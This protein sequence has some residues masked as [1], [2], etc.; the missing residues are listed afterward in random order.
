VATGQELRILQG[1]TSR[2]QGVAFS[3]DGARL[4]SAGAGVVKLWDA[5]TGQELR[6]LQGGGVGVAFSPDGARLASAGAGR[7]KLWD[8]ATGEELRTLQGGGGSVAF[9]SDWARLASGS[10]DGSVKLWDAATGQELR[11]LQAYTG[12]GR[13]VS[14]AF[15]PDGARLASAGGEIGKPGE[16]KLWDARPLTPELKVELE[17]RGLVEF[18]CTQAKVQEE[19]TARIRSNKM[20]SEPV[21]QQALAYVPTYWAARCQ[22]DGHPTLFHLLHASWQW[23]LLTGWPRP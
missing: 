2:V 18:V 11:T 13:V 10:L 17:A 23:A 7:V 6:T 16:V 8:A 21:R 19:A 14:V 20:I 12:T 5:A 22:A 9:S 4:A 15:S 3:P 1:H